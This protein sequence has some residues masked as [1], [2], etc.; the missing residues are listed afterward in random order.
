[1]LTNTHKHTHMHALTQRDTHMHKHTHTLLHTCASNMLGLAA[2]MLAARCEV[3]V[4][5]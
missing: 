4:R 1:M 3:S 5:S 2:S